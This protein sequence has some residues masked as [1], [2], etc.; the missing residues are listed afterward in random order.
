[1]L[2]DIQIYEHKVAYTKLYLEQ[3]SVKL[4]FFV[5]NGNELVVMHTLKCGLPLAVCPG[6]AD[7]IQ[8]REGPARS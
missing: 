2:C 6:F 7:K 3:N 5:H 1:M 8:R 4:C